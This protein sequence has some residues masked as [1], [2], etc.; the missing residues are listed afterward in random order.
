MSA[1]WLL[2]AALLTPA[3]GQ[4]SGDEAPAQVV[5][6][7]AP[8]PGIRE[9]ASTY[10]RLVA[11]RELLAEGKPAE[12]AQ[13]AARAVEL[14][15]RNRQAYDVLAAANRALGNYSQLLY[16][17]ELG[18][19]TF[20]NDP[21]LLKNKVF[22]LNKKRDYA[23]A[24]TAADRALAVHATDAALHALRAYALGQS[25]DREGMLK[26]LET[27]AALDPGLESLRL[28]ARDSTGGDPFTMPG[29]RRAPPVSAARVK[30]PRPPLKGLL[31]LGGLIV[32]LLVMLGLLA[33]GSGRRRN[34]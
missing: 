27:A 32:L 25:G 17:A 22:A 7:P 28:E 16:V 20:P 23:A 2:A 34:Q 24:L 15:P 9:E 4:D 12:A 11:A 13:S 6:A 33:A 10:E 5:A 30:P 1:A 29:D 31:I 14:Q 21:D 8:G 18:L 26:A 3:A 19:K